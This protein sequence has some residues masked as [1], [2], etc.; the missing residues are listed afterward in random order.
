MYTCPLHQGGQD[1]SS[2]LWNSILMVHSDPSACPHVQQNATLN[3]SLWT[4]KVWTKI[5][6]E[7]L[8]LKTHGLR[9]ILSRKQM[10][11]QAPRSQYSVFLANTLPLLRASKNQQSPS[12]FLLLIFSFYTPNSMGNFKE[13]PLS[14]QN[15]QEQIPDKWK[16]LT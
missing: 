3:T 1:S 11:L 13:I 9:V 10:E 4:S 6:W 14:T 16:H 2:P 7:R 8:A 5:T 12:S 15:S